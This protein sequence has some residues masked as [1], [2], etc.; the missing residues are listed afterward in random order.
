MKFI[1]SLSLATAILSILLFP[2][3][4]LL[5]A[6]LTWDATPGDAINEG[7]GVWLDA[8]QWNNGSPNASWSNSTP[9]N[10]IIGAGGGSA[11]SNYVITLGAVTA[12]SLTFTNF[13]GTYVLTNGNLVVNDTIAI[14]TNSGPVT[15]Y[16]PISGSAGITKANTNTLFLLST[17]SFTGNISINAGILQLG[18]GNPGTAMT[19]GGGTYAG[20]IFIAGGATLNC[21]MIATQTFSGDITG[22][23]NVVIANGTFTFSGNN[24]YT[25][26]TAIKQQKAGGNP[27]L[28]VSS[29]NSVFTNPDLGTV[30]S[31]SS[32]LGAP[33]T[34]V[35]GTFQLGVSNA[36]CAPTLKYNGPGETT[37]RIINIQYGGTGPSYTPILDASGSGLLKFTSA[38]QSNGGNS[39]AP[40][41]L[42]GIGLGEIIQGLPQ[43]AKGGL[44]KDGSGTWTLGGSL[45]NA[46]PLTVSAGTLNLNGTNATGTGTNTITVTGGTLNLN[47][48]NVISGRPVTISGNGRLNANTPRALGSSAITVT[49]SATLALAADRSLM[50][51][52]SLTVFG[53]GKVQLDAG[54][55]ATVGSLFFGTN[56]QATG[57][58]G[59]TNSAA[60]NTSTNFTGTGKLYVGVEIPGNGTMLLIQ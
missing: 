31:A 5:A 37:D 23:G 17:N 57:S 44:K 53:A 48:T 42:S 46:G 13:A 45:T 22:D 16:T 58:W 6:D 18:I 27:T 59:S 11:S 60:Q 20:S 50:S 10:A 51:T 28:I 54:G 49:N 9:D 43:L 39:G 29:F 12:G 7:S 52:N 34:V 1:Y 38:F 36:Q 21:F 40:F 56:S 26:T 24:T 55:K 47:A 25:G 14:A 30:H 41:V 3:G 35:N 15:L 33:T 32:S 4:G 2:A 19:L 8:G